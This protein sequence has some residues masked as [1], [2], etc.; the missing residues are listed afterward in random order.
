MSN[1]LDVIDHLRHGLSQEQLLHLIYFDSLRHARRGSPGG[2]GYTYAVPDQWQGKHSDI[3]VV[4]DRKAGST[5]IQLFRHPGLLEQLQASL[6][7]ALNFVCVVRNPFDTITTTFKK[8]PRLDGETAEEHLRR[9]IERYFERWNAIAH[10][11]QAVGTGNIAFVY[12]EEL[13]GDPSATLK[14]LCRFLDIP[15][16]EPYLSA[17]ASVVRRD[18]HVTRTSIEWQPEMLD[19]V[20]QKCADVPW[21]RHYSY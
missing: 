8:T 1:E 19:L 7:L 10:V 9:Q 12:H 17:C 15:S 14:K 20:Q 5:A 6:R 2:G 4:G 16:D 11:A 13:I 18:P 3:R 21:I